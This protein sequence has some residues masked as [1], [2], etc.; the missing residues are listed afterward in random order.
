MSGSQAAIFS[1]TPGQ[2]ELR[3]ISPPQPAAGEILVRVL[4]CTLC[5]SD[6]HTFEG[7]RQAPVP[8][9]LGHEIVGQIEQ[10][11]GS[12]L[13]QD[14]AGQRLQ[15]RDRV[16][17]AIVAS[18]GECFFCQH[19]LP[20]KCVS[21]V[22]YG[23]ESLKPS[24]EL[25]GGLA[26]HCLL[27]PG[28]SIVRLPDDLPLE[29][30][31]PANCATATAMAAIEAAGNLKNSVV[32]VLGA[33]L[34]GLTVSAIARTHGAAE[35]ICVELR[36][37][38]REQ[39]RQFGVT[40]PIGPEA[41]LDTA[42]ELTDGRGVDVV[43]ELSGSSAAFTAAWPTV[44]T[45]GALV[46]VGAVFPGPPVELYLEQLIRRHLTI[47]GIHNYAPRHLLQ[48]I[49]F[50]ESQHRTYPFASLVAQWQPLAEIAQAFENA[51]DPRK[52]RV[53]VCP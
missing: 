19:D 14:M 2:V 50:L 15:P 51:R 46:V 17:W 47:R 52:I 36:P 4:G 13:I 39:A 26:Q 7:R 1:G 12:G 6:L 18:C 27:V 41:L 11:G 25:L 3:E 23:H 33:G 28:T 29:V 5:G 40:H 42:K 21:S 8:T 22:K 45:G 44:R 43:F 30:A 34:L 35:I 10:I 16:S 38:R 31:C 32:C 37:E 24:R 20:Q 9:V 49:Q 53:G 48:A